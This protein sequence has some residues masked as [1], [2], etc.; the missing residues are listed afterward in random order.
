[1]DR[2]QMQKV[3]ELNQ[4]LLAENKELLQSIKEKKGSDVINAHVERLKKIR[5][6][7]QNIRDGKVL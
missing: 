7:I 1:M 4:L 3:I 2:E 5:I 6:Q